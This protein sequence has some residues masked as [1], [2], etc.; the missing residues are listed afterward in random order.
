VVNSRAFAT[1]DLDT[2]LIERER[3]ALFEAPPLAL[4]LVAAAGVVRWHALAATSAARLEDGRPLVAPRRLAAARRRARRFDLELAGARCGALERLHDG[5]TVLQIG[6][7][8]WRL[9]RPRALGGAGH[10][11]AGWRRAPAPADGLRHGERVA[12]FAAEGSA[13]ATE[14]TPSP[15]PATTRRGRPADRADAGQGDRLPRQGRARRSARPG[16]GGDGGDEDGAHLHAPRDGVVRNCS[17][18]WATRWPKAASCCGWHRPEPWPPATSRTIAPAG[19][20]AAAGRPVQ[21][22]GLAVAGSVGCRLRRWHR[23]QRRRRRSPTQRGQSWAALRAWPG[24]LSRCSAPMACEA[25]R[26]CRAS[27]CQFGR[28]AG[29]AD[30][31]HI[32]GIARV[33][34]ACAPHRCPAVLAQQD[35]GCGGICRRAG[36][37]SRQGSRQVAQLVRRLGASPPTAPPQVRPGVSV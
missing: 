9:R 11:V 24:G 8:R 3:A 13:G 17:T 7:Q 25:S 37:G 15:T 4:E 5:A 30:Q 34:P 18:R 6:E 28:R 27:G 36:A 33:V 16:A 20:P 2:A 26:K 21:S 35:R 19:Q 1:A 14:S 12:V 31:Q 32:A 22:R 29:L 10:D 23:R